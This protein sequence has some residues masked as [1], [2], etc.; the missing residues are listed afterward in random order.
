MRHGTTPGGVVP[1]RA[2]LR[3]LLAGSGAETAFLG[4]LGFTES[5]KEI[6]YQGVQKGDLVIHAMDA[7]PVLLGCPTQTE[8]PH[9]STLFASHAPCVTLSNMQRQMHRGLEAP[10]FRAISDLRI[11]SPVKP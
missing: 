2:A 1:A 6:G 7:L 4:T 5:L 3:R 10:L 11:N 9:L 8:N